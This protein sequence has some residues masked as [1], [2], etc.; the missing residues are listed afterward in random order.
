MTTIT[1]PCTAGALV[2][3]QVRRAVK[4]YCWARGYTFTVEED[5]GF[6]ESLLYFEI[7]VPEAEA[8]TALTELKAWARENKS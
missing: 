8:K 2:R 5:K 3:G 1:I 7:G 4:Q 6:F